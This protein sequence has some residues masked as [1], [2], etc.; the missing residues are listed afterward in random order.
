MDGRSLIKKWWFH[1]VMIG[2]FIFFICLP[3]IYL[4]CV[5]CF[6]TYSSSQIQ[7]M[8]PLDAHC[9]HAI[10]VVERVNLEKLNWLEKAM[11]PISAV[12]FM[13]SGIVYLVLMGVYDENYEK[14][15]EEKLRKQKEEAES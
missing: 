10:D 3:P 1:V 5:G 2:L 6:T 15:R 7:G 11:L 14:K 4:V 12:G 9:N 8:R 13:I